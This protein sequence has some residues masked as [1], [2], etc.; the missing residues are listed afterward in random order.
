MNADKQAKIFTGM[1]PNS[2]E[3]MLDNN[4]IKLHHEV[5]SVFQQFPRHLIVFATSAYENDEIE[6][7][8]KQWRND[9]R[10]YMIIA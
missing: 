5:L 3:S 10:H 6:F 4:Q 9:R 2:F 8:I 7:F 1:P